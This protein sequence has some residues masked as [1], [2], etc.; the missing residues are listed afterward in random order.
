MSPPS[1]AQT[2]TTAAK[3]RT[4]SLHLLS[5]Y[6][7][8]S[9]CKGTENQAK[10]RERSPHFYPYFAFIPS[11]EP[12]CQLF[13]HW[14]LRSF[15]DMLIAL[16]KPR[17][18]PLVWGASIPLA[19]VFINTFVWGTNRPLTRGIPDPNGYLFAKVANKSETQSYIAIFFT[20]ISL[21][22]HLARVSRRLLPCLE[23]KEP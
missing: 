11:H 23:L 10:T 5:P 16:L 8:F 9:E 14:R 20:L 4:V 12:R 15:V 13:A 6:A 1:L 18:I 3:P 19:W 17:F 7:F 21:S 22:A 2:P